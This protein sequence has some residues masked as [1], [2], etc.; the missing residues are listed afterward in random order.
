[1]DLRPG[2]DMVANTMG[3]PNINVPEFVDS[4]LRGVA[5]AVPGVKSSTLTGDY[6]KSSFS[7]EKAADNDTWPENFALQKLIA[8]H[9][10]QDVWE[11]LAS[12]AVTSGVIDEPDDYMVDPDMYLACNWQGPVP[13][14]INPKDDAEADILSM[15]NGFESLQSIA[16]RRGS[17]WREVLTDMAEVYEFAGQKG[18][19]ESFIN[20]LYGVMPEM[21]QTEDEPA[22]DESDDNDEEVASGQEEAA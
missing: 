1:M 20:T 17:N 13:K 7:S 21:T 3:G 6:R 2:E 4:I 15:K 16:S 10:L 14:S 12:D 18:L 5:T 11:T 19:N 22:D 9:F 8:N